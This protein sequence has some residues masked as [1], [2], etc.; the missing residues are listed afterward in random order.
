MPDTATQTAPQQ[1]LAD[2][3]ARVEERIAAAC[4]RAG[5]S[6]SEITLVAVTKV[7][8]TDVIRA[9]RAEGLSCFGENRARELRDKAGELPGAFEGGDGKTPVVEWHMVGHLQR[10]KAK[11][12]ARHADVFQALDSPRLADELDKRAAKNDRVL[13]CLA[14][15]NITGAEQKYGLAPESLHAFLDELASRKHLR[16]EGL[17][18][19]ASYTD[20]DEKVR[21]QFSRMKEL[22]DTY[23]AAGNPRV[24]MKCLSMGMSNDFEIAVEEG[25]T[26]LRLGSALFGPRPYDD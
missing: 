21:G 19:M 22:F 14:Q 20:D 7:F 10:N 12:V 25:A 2:R 17:M 15:V 11:F 6:R 4:E 5:R 16:V 13:P 9:A 26:M 23:D 3:L 24:E 18:A 8:P 1:A